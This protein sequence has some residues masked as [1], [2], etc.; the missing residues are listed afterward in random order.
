L[1][2]DEGGVGRGLQPISDVLAA[3]GD[4]E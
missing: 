1:I 2:V 4:G 3:K